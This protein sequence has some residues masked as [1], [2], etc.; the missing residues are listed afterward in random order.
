MAQGPYDFAID[1]GASQTVLSEKLAA[2]LGLK[3]V[4]TTIMHGVG[5]AGKVESKI[6]RLDEIGVGDVKVRNLPVG[7]FNDPL[8]TQLADGIIGTAMLSDFIITV[9]YPENQLELVERPNCRELTPFRPG[10]SATFCLWTL[11][12]T[13]NTVETSSSTPVR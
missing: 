12:S 2:E 3:P 6:Y 13:D 5:G 10:T 1:T 4:T 7:T 9:N 11:K 8:V